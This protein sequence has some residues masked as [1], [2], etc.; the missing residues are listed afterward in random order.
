ME[1]THGPEVL[2]EHTG[3]VFHVRLNRP[4]VLNAQTPEMW[5]Q[6][7]ATARTLPPEV[8]AVVISGVGSSFSAGL[9]R[10]MFTEG[11]GADPSLVHLAAASD[12]DVLTAIAAFQEAFTV[13]REIRPVTIAAVHGHAIGAGFQLALAADMIVCSDDSRFAMKETSLGLVPDLGGTE[14]LLDAVG[15]SQALHMCVTGRTVSG[16]QAHQLGLAVEL[17]RVDAV[18]DAATAL[19]SGI[20]LS[21][22]DAAED[23]KGLL[24]ARHRLQRA[25]Q[26]ERER[27]AQLGRIKSLA[28]VLGHTNP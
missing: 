21:A 16:E 12:E 22:P 13:W 25:E 11:I 26:V 28:K 6:L 24:G 3:A 1:T 5:R 10:R 9:D 23:L 14:V 19:A 8:R 7:I 15:Y 18:V 27:V 17:T 20:A 2:T 4:D